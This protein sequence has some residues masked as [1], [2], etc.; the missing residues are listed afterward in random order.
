VGLRAGELNLFDST[1]V[2]ISS[3]A[4]AVIIVSFV[5]MFFIAAACFYL[6]RRDPN[7]GASYAWISKLVGPDIGWFNGWVQLAASVLFCVAS[8]WLLCGFC[9]AAPLLAA[10]YTLPFLP[11]PATRRRVRGQA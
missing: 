4:P 11:G 8:V 9:V 10:S 3:V 5:P 1:V 2:A 6:N 7:C